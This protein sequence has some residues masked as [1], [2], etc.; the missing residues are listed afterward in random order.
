MSIPRNKPAPAAVDAVALQWA[1]GKSMGRA[2]GTKDRFAPFVGFHIEVGKDDDL[3]RALHGLGMPVV[4]IKHQRPGG[5][6]VIRHWALGEELTLFVVTAGPP[7]AAMAGCTAHPAE[8]AAAGIGARWGIGERSKLA[9][10]CYVEPLVKAGYLRLVQLSVRSRMTDVLLAA[11]V[12]HARVCEATDSLIDR[13]RH[14]D[15]VCFHEVGLLLA[16]GD[17]QQW[18]KGES[19]EVV[20][21][22]SAHPESIDAGYL[23]QLWRP[24]ALHAAALRDWP[25]IQAWAAEYAAQTEGSARAVADEPAL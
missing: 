7:V 2:V 10:R 24:D 13:V 21:F 9:V 19:T 25:S 23:R 18:G 8:T 5:A 20:P 11:L 22:T 17:P 1:N 6:E 4:E 15:L 16:A 12:D 3:D 14:P